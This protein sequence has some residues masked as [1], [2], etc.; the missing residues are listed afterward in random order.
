[1]SVRQVTTF[2]SPVAIWPSF[3]LRDK[4]FDRRAI[5]KADQVK[6]EK[7]MTMM[8][9]I[10]NAIEASRANENFNGT[11]YFRGEKKE[12]DKID[13]SE[14]EEVLVISLKRGRQTAVRILSIDAIEISR[15]DPPS[16]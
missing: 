8:A 2:G 16:G 14:D 13:L 6:R 11:I 7:T 12:F 5:R 1:M 9:H 4:R 15:D 10:R 3:A